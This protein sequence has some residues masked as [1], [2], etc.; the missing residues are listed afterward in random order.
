MMRVGTLRRRM[1]GRVRSISFSLHVVRA[2]VL[3]FSDGRVSCACQPHVSVEAGD[4]AL[5][6]GVLGEL[7]GEADEDGFALLSVAVAELSDGEHEAGEG[8]EV[9][10]AFGGELEQTD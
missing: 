7:P 9:V 2:S 1:G 6:E 8:G 10:A 3:D 4:L 5:V